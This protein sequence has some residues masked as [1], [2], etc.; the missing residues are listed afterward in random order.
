MIVHKNKIWR[1]G[2]AQNIEE[3]LRENQTVAKNENVRA[4]FVK[5]VCSS[6]ILNFHKIIPVTL[7]LALRVNTI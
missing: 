2:E 3:S 5:F 4:E 6:V 7:K 1:L